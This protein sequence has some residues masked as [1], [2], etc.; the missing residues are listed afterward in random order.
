MCLVVERLWLFL[1]VKKGKSSYRYLNVRRMVCSR[2]VVFSHQLW[3]HPEDTGG[4]DWGARVETKENRGQ[5]HRAV[6]VRP[7][8]KVRQPQ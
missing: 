1:L 7:P 2:V 8:W 6:D 3:P 4:N 5:T